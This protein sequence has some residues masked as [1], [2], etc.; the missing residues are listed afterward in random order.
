[1]PSAR[2]FNP[3]TP[4]NAAASAA[5]WSSALDEIHPA[6]IDYRDRLR[7]VPPTSRLPM[8]PILNLVL[9]VLFSRLFYWSLGHYSPSYISNEARLEKVSWLS[10]WRHQGLMDSG[11]ESITTALATG[12]ADCLLRTLPTAPEVL[13]LV[14]S[15]F[16]LTF[17]SST[18]AARRLESL[19]SPRS[20]RRL[21]NHSGP[22]CLRPSARYPT[23]SCLSDHPCHAF[24][25]DRRG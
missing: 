7:A 5:F 18:L 15:E 8:L 6:D 17:G 24:W 16:V 10:F 2:P 11:L 12:R 23:A 9:V 19:V 14:L 3:D 22:G 13:D 4:A 1:M 20:V 21:C 25:E